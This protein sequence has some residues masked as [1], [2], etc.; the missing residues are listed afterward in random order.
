MKAGVLFRIGSLWIGAHYS[1][2]ERRWCINFVPCLT[3]WVCLKGGRP[4]LLAEKKKNKQKKDNKNA[5]L[6]LQQFANSA[7]SD[8]KVQDVGRFH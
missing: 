7:T 4:P 8:T 3:L 2:Y 6:L 1:P 5:M